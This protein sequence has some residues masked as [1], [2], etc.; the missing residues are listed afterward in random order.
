MF[1]DS[2]LTSPAHS[3][4]VRD[5]WS[6][7]TRWDN[8]RSSARGERES[9][10]RLQERAEFAEWARER[11]RQRLLDVLL[12]ERELAR[13]LSPRERRALEL[14]RQRRG[15]MEWRIERE[16]QLLWEREKIRE[17][18][19]RGRRSRR[20][21]HFDEY[22]IDGYSD[23]RGDS[24]AG[25][26]D[27]DMD[28][29]LALEREREAEMLR[30][31]LREIDRERAFARERERER[32]RERP[33]R[34]RGREETL[35][36]MTPTMHV[37]ETSEIVEEINNSDGADINVRVPSGVERGAG[38]G[39]DNNAETPN[40]KEDGQEDSAEIPSDKKVG[41]AGAAIPSD[42]DDKDDDVEVESNNREFRPHHD[43]RKVKPTVG[44]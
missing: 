30:A 35:E 13:E 32:A 39:D 22:D 2:A 29:R 8:D 18:A 17:A 28:M 43:P 15:E 16:R 26:R 31:R 21:D 10:R 25:W 36:V 44:K 20:D 7:T 24:R 38:R 12:R 42:S 34:R 9:S 11:E 37:V 3:S 41:D 5:E 14:E 23:E 1:E 40:D 27:G 6:E 19:R 33:S 4:S